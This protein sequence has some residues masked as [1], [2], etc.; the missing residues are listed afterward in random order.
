MN[1][2]KWA[3]IWLAINHQNCLSRSLVRRKAVLVSYYLDHSVGSILEQV[4]GE[5]EVE[6]G[7]P[8]SSE[9]MAGKWKQLCVHDG[10]YSTV[11][12]SSITSTMTRSTPRCMAT[13]VRCQSERRMNWSS[14]HSSS[15]TARPIWCLC[16]RNILHMD[17]NNSNT[18]FPLTWKTR[19]FFV[20][21]KTFR[22]FCLNWNFWCAK[23][24][25]TVL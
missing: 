6:T 19:A 9:N 22:T 7:W 15:F 11:L 10:V 16:R 24:I 1:L 17:Y 3:V 25:Y 20:I 4:E 23:S 14:T 5:T 21:W 12:R 8:S 13:T 18:G 2:H